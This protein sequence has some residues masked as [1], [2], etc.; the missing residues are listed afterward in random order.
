MLLRLC[1][2]TYSHLD[3]DV[4]EMGGGPAK[5]LARHAQCTSTLVCSPVQYSKCGSLS[6]FYVAACAL[7]NPWN[8]IMCDTMQ[9]TVS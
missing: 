7:F 1:T 3:P 9:K 4:L 2:L 8:E 5:I 6:I